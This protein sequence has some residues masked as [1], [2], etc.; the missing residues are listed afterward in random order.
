VSIL[1]IVNWC[2]VWLGHVCFVFVLLV[3]LASRNFYRSYW[4]LSFTMVLSC[5][6]SLSVYRRPI[7]PWLSIVL[8]SCDP[9]WLF[10][11]CRMT[12][13]QAN[14]SIIFDEQRFSSVVGV[15]ETCGQVDG[16]GDRMR[17]EG[18][19][20]EAHQRTNEKRASDDQ[21]LEGK[22]IGEVCRVI[23]KNKGLID[24]SNKVSI[25]SS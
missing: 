20:A 18:V 12:W 7:I 22:P 9:S 25:K 10:P 6:H 2:Y 24:H 17:S 1:W 23:R 21:I 4:I 19:E 15:V 8:L 14:K 13:Y 11:S 3:S 16:F 5:T